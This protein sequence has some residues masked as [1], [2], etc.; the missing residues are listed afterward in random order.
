MA[1]AM[2]LIII[3]DHSKE[4]NIILLAEGITTGF[5]VYDATGYPVAITYNCHNLLNI[6]KILRKKHP[7]TKLLIISDDDR[8]H[9]EINL[10]DAGAKAAKKVCAN[11]EDVSYVL[12]DFEALDLSEKQLNKLKPTDMN[13]LFVHLISGGV[14]EDDA[15]AII[16]EQ[17]LTAAF[18]SEV[19]PHSAILNQLLEKV[20][21][22]NFGQLAE[23]KEGEAL[24]NSQYQVIVIDQI[25]MLA[26]KQ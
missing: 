16:H 21:E 12:P 17:I 8:W 25:L 10:R 11:I 14:D 5:T 24:K 20:T 7:H 3:G 4:Y 1:N 9:S 19:M 23:L 2:A 22:V 26:K 15:F 6:A 13:D 18:K